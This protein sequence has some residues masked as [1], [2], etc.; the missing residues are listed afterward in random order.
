MATTQI[1]TG[2]V[3]IWK[4][5][6]VLTLLEYLLE[7]EYDAKQYAATKSLSLF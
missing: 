7:Y 5:W 4:A 3:L 1:C 2:M 6:Y